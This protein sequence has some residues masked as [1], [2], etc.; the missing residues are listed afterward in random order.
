M[1]VMY[2]C[3]WAV[4]ECGP[5]QFRTSTRQCCGQTA[6]YQVSA[7]QPG[8]WD[9]EAP[10]ACHF[11]SWMSLNIQWVQHTHYSRG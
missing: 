4:D 2:L 7:M 9:T 6:T 10:R 8:H 5:R 11:W 3:Y 1:G